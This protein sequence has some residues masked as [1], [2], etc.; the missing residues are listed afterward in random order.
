[1][2]LIEGRLRRAVALQSSL[3]FPAVAPGAT[4][5]VLQCACFS[6]VG[7][8][9]SAVGCLLLRRS[10][11]LRALAAW[12]CVF[13]S[14]YARKG[15]NPS[16]LTDGHLS[17]SAQVTKAPAPNKHPR[18]RVVLVRSTSHLAAPVSRGV[19]RQGVVQ[20]CLEQRGACGASSAHARPLE[21]LVAHG[22]AMRAGC[23]LSVA[24]LTL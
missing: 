17:T 8:L 12:M 20:R 18:V 19:R 6:L 16:V 24:A 13:P 21:L 7:M 14:G 1:M 15:I 10:V 2:R 23:I 9:G 22:L 4:W 3:S 5:A 11:D